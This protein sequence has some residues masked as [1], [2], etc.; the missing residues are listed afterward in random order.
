MG[1]IR[2][3][4]TEVAIVGAGPAGL[5]AACEIAKTGKKVAVFDENGRPGGQLFKQI[6][7]FFGSS[8]HGAGIRGVQIGEK[9]LEDCEEAGVE[10]YLNAVVYGIFPE[11]ELGVLIDGIS[12]RVKTKKVLIATGA[13]EKALAF[14]G[15]DKPGVMGAGAFQTMMNVNYVLPGQKVVMVG[16]GN[17]GLVVAYQILQAGG[18][19]EAVIEAAP[20]VTGYSVHANKLKRQGVKILTSHTVKSVLGEFSVEQVEIAEVDDKFQIIEGTEKILDADTVCVAVGLTPSVELLKMAGV[21][22]TFLPPMGGFLPLHNEYMETSNPD[23]YVAGDASGIEEASSAI[24]EGKLSGVCIAGAI[25]GLTPE[26][27]QNRIQEIKESLLAL[28]SGKGGEGRREGNQEIIRRYEK[29]KKKNQDQL[30]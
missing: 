9:L 19:V 11:V 7:K 3:I 6:H 18:C 28:R 27:Q 5:S 30:L 25:G 12:V 10:I 4:E 13:T 17:V 29:W 21:E 14:K 20:T 24:E 22:M 23:I 15:W 8:R 26:E 1:R 2:E 16:S